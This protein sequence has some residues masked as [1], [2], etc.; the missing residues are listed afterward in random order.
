LRRCGQRS[1]RRHCW[2]RRHAGRVPWSTRRNRGRL[3]VLRSI[4]CTNSIHGRNGRIRRRQEDAIRGR[5]R[6]HG[7][8]NRHS[9][10]GACCSS[11]RDKT[12][13]RHGRMPSV[14]RPAVLAIDEG[15][16]SAIKNDGLIFNHRLRHPA[17]RGRNSGT[18][19]SGRDARFKFPRRPLQHG[20]ALQLL[21]RYDF[22]AFVCISRRPCRPGDHFGQ[23]ICRRAVAIERAPRHPSH[24]IADVHP[25]H[26]GGLPVPQSRRTSRHPDPA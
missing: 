4:R 24:L 13:R 23:K 26:A 6:R 15:M 3:S 25:V 19:R 5:L 1:G 12:S 18:L 20:G 2:P 10:N 11:L 7:R 9:R 16:S 14:V 17:N 22:I 8:R 21:A